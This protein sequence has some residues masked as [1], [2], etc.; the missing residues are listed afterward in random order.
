MSFDDH[1]ASLTER[2]ANVHVAYGGGGTGHKDEE[3]DS[4]VRDKADRQTRDQVLDP[5]TEHIL[6]QMVNKGL[7]TELHGVISTGKEANV[8]AAVLQEAESEGG[9][10]VHRAVKVY[11]TAILS[12]VD[13]ERYITGEHRF[14][15]GDHKG[16]HRKMVKKWAEKEFRN[17]QRLR[18]AGIA[19][20]HPIQVKANVL[21]MSFLGDARGNAYP[22]LRDV[23][24]REGEPDWTSLY[25][26]LLGLVRR[27][28]QDC[29]LVHAD[30]SEYNVLY[31]GGTLYIIDVS[32]SVGHDHPQAFDFL[33]TD[34]HNVGVFFRRHGVDT[35]R[36]R[37]VFDFVRAA[38]AADA[39]DGAL[40]DAL[41]GALDALY[42]SRPAA[43]TASLEAL[44]ADNEVFRS[45][46][47]PHSLQQVYDGEMV[48]RG[49]GPLGTATEDGEVLY[50]DLLAGKAKEAGEDSDGDGDD[51]D[52]SPSAS[53]DSSTGSGVS[54]ANSDGDEF[55]RPP[56]R[57]KRFE[58]KEAKR[59]H[60]QAIKE[61]KRLKRQTKMP[62]KVKKRLVHATAKK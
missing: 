39:L 58:D 11:K 51:G 26:Q 17:L 4:R 44:E 62:K 37:A 3:R 45:Q 40:N 31:H 28:Y 47:I 54:L 12:F 25:R 6:L 57:G 36:D 60:K 24:L 52:D 19:C 61:E 48:A 59:T 49:V 5:R 8:Y 18:R 38:P 30:L 43:D 14:R 42:A 15:S 53:D 16:N 33:R 35:L 10:V 46:Y 2:V 41:D 55:S 29:R 56:P 32:Q 7:V 22:R 20:P 50:R 9:G 1:V 21:L 34:M 23:V 13:R 27:L